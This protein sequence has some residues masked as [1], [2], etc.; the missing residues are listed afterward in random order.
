MNNNLS[1]YTIA[2]VITLVLLQTL[3]HFN[4]PTRNWIISST[5]KFVAATLNL[6]NR[7]LHFFLMS[8]VKARAN[9]TKN[10]QE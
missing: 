6:G 5:H 1:L 10:S 7:F 8:P 9:T 3:F 4:K 2:L